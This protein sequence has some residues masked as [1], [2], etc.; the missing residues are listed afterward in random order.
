MEEGVK[1]G[2]CGHL[3]SG[4]RQ[5]CIIYKKSKQN[6]HKQMIPL[7]CEMSTISL[8][9]QAMLMFAPRCVHW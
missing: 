3:W 7:R 9:I 8:H 5:A 4:I 6:T 2:I 1:I